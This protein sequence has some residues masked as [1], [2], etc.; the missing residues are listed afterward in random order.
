MITPCFLSLILLGVSVA[1]AQEETALFAQ[2]R[3]NGARFAQMAQAARRVLHAWMAQADPRTSLLPE[4][5][6]GGTHGLKPGDNTRLFTPHN[7]GADLYPYLILTAHLTDPELCRGRLMEMLRNEI[8][9]TTVQDSIPAN[10]D[11]NT[12]ALGPPSLF[13]AGEY[14]KDGLLAV[15]ELL[16]RT[17]WFY[18][19]ADMTADIMKH[20]PVHSRFGNLPASDAELNGDV[21]Q[22]LVR[23]ATMTGD[24][25]FLEWARRIGDA[26]FDEVL[27]GSHGLP[28]SNWNFEAHTGDGKLRLRDHGNETVVGLSLL[29]ALEQYLDTPRA[30]RY[31]PLMARMLDRILESANPDGLLYNTIDTAALKPLDAGLADTWGYVYGAV[32]TFYQC[33]GETKYRNATQRVLKN[34]TK[35]RNY[36]WENG[37]FDGYADS[38]ESALYLAAREP[39]PEA[40]DWIESEIQVMAA[41][42]KPSGL[43]EHWY[44]EGNFNRTLLLYMYYKSQGCRPERWV[45]GFEIGAVR[46]GERLYLS[47]GAAGPAAGWKG[48]ICF[49]F[50]RHRRVMNFD[51][52]YVRLNEFPEWYTV[53]ENTLYKVRRAGGA[54]GLW[55]GSELI[56]GVEFEPGDWIVEPLG[57]PPYGPSNRIGK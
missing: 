25:R 27:P 37:S 39:V 3:Q 19:M 29:Y 43:I 8:R 47:V 5:L 56:A 1:P 35:Y 38:I 49:D 9:Y 36:D 20:A 46:R 21:L 24:R 7:S 18:R 10:L 14:A 6:P 31:R 16:G 2:A 33:T 28:S 26:Y 55:L 54:E 40:L 42:Q 12:G 32:Y 51:K 15:T 44:G 4:R 53:D 34:I 48:R 57:A 52:N 30:A 41:M 22:A 23:L 17:P 11:L 45:P 13:G 50:A